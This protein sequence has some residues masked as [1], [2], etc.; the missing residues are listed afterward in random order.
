MSRAAFQ[1]IIAAMVAGALGFGI[2]LYVVPLEEIVQFRAL[3]NAGLGA[4]STKIHPD[5][6]NTGVEHPAAPPSTASTEPASPARGRQDANSR[7]DPRNA[8]CVG[9]SPNEAATP[10]DIP[11]HDG[12]TQNS[13][14]TD[15]GGM[16]QAP[17]RESEPARSPILSPHGGREKAQVAP[18]GHSKRPAKKAKPKG[19]PPSNSET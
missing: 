12:V 5:N 18:G 15:R 3:I 7:C 14:P 9:G 4:N 16:L 11:N 1:I 6:G 10:S 8:N 19:A 13:R 17:A 2:A